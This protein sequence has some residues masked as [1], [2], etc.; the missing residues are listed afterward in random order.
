MPFR[1]TAAFCAAFFMFMFMLASPAAGQ[2][3]PCSD[4][5]VVLE[6]LADKYSEVL[7][8]A[9]VINRGYLIELLTS[10]GGETWTLIVSRPNGVACLVAA[11]EGW[12][13][14]EPPK[15]QGP[16]L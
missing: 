6:H 13:T 15:P 10:K 16:A 12:R 2:S 1:L 3:M 5:A 4:R 8:G 7:A 9:G 11:G 14:K